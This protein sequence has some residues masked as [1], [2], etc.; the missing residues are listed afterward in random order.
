MDNLAIYEEGKTLKEDGFTISLR[1]IYKPGKNA[2]KDHF[3]HK[4]NT[5]I[6]VFLPFAFSFPAWAEPWSWKEKDKNIIIKE[7]V[8]K[9]TVTS[10]ELKAWNY[11]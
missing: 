6:N 8:S 10:A 4:A 9:I 5:K 2:S 1:R 7:V 11:N 3:S